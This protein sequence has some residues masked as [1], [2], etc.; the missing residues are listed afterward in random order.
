MKI[1]RLG[2]MAMRRKKRG[3]FNDASGKRESKLTM[4]SWTRTLTMK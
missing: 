1:W 4:Y 2:E 3:K